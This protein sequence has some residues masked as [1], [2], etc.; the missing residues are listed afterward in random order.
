MWRG[1]ALDLVMFSGRCRASSST[2]DIRCRNRLISSIAASL[3]STEYRPRKRTSTWCGWISSRFSLFSLMLCLHCNFDDRMM[4]RT[5]VLC[6]RRASRRFL[7]VYSHVSFTG[8]SCRICDAS[9]HQCDP[10]NPLL[11][12]L[13]LHRR[14]RILIV[15]YYS[16]LIWSH[17]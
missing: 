16:I 15:V 14:L 6:R 4:A 10:V 2:S 12:S 3:I 1:R 13:T 8:I 5:N 7:G 17:K 11:T 9:S